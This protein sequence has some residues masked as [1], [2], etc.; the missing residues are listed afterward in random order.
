[1]NIANAVLWW[2]EETRDVQITERP[3][4]IGFC[5]GNWCDIGANN[6][7]W[8]A[9]HEDRKILFFMTAAICLSATKN[10]PIGNFLNAF[11]QVS[12]MSHVLVDFNG[13]DFEKE[14]VA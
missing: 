11:S 10:I 4:R 1:M 9:L 6:S 5:K 2:N 14:E 12:E 8:K 13:M 7:F 3:M